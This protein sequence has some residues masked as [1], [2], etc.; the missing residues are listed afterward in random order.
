M[1]DIPVLICVSGALKGQRF[2]VPDGGLDLGRADENNIVICD[3]GV[4]RFHA[5][6]LYDNGQLWLQDAGS[7]N[8]VFVDDHR[9]TG[10]KS[11]KV[12][13]ILRIANHT[14]E[15]RWEDESKSQQS[16]EESKRPWYWP[17]S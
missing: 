15:V 11:L 13:H 17:F 2:V 10:H 5:R 16:A 1:A 8:G 14:F 3:D 6:I 4:S 9:V 7:R 12:G